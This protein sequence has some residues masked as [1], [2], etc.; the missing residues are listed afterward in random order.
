[1]RTALITLLTC[2]AL[3]P[4]SAFARFWDAP[5]TFE[6]DCNRHQT[7]SRALEHASDG[8]TI[9]VFGECHE[10]VTV[11]IGVTLDGGGSARVIP[12]EPAAQSAFTVTAREVTVRGFVLDAP[13]VFQFFVLGM[14]K[15]TIESNTIRNA[16]N[17]GISAAAN[18][19]VTILD[20]VVDSN[21]FGGVIGL[22]G[23]R[24]VIGSATGFSP[25]RPNVISDNA[26]VGV[27]VVSNASAMVLG[28]NTISGHRVGIQVM[29][30]GQSRI[31]GNLID[32]NDIG[33]FVD[34]GGNVQLP[35]AVNPVPAFVALNSGSN[36]TGIA[37]KGGSIR[38]VPEGL[39]P[40]I[41]L[42]PTPGLLGGPSD[43]LPTHCLDQTEPP[44]AP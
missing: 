8:D 31:A 19:V 11:D 13:A 36:T 34:A 23:A 25:P 35:V 41:K 30:G 38:G 40:T 27:V 43:G 22:T 1:M 17:F 12:P 42:P 10:A 44:A 37:C 18:S 29:D 26:N 6:V 15:L 32:G 33:I 9:R 20:N 16:Q 5:R 21:N 24:L 28:G 7:I 39:S 14:A 3:A 2:C 4:A